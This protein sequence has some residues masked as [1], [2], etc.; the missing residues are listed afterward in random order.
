MSDICI[1]YKTMADGQQVPVCSIVHSDG[2]LSGV[3]IADEYQTLLENLLTTNTYVGDKVFTPEDDVEAWMR[4]M[5][6]TYSNGYLRA[7]LQEGKDVQA[8]GPGSGWT[9]EEGHVSHKSK[10]VSGGSVHVKMQ[11][12]AEATEAVLAKVLGGKSYNDTE[13]VD[14]IVRNDGRAIGIEV[15]TLFYQKNDK[16]TMNHGSIGRKEKWAKKTGAELYTVAVDTRNGKN[17]CYVRKGVGSWQLK[18]MEKVPNGMA[19]VK[20][21]LG[22]KSKAVEDLPD[23]FPKTKA[24]MGV[25]STHEWSAPP[26][27]L[28]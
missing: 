3:Y 4:A 16:I 12:A 1:F 20:N 18:Y 27:R 14:I 25:P 2:A 19:G 23:K 22:I 15:K 11:M 28:R 26:K 10:D 7:Y 6:A 13:P 17:D 8:G 21:Y 24:K 9:T 5:P